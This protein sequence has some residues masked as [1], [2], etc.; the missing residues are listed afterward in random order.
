MQ[1]AIYKNN[2]ARYHDRLH[3]DINFHLFFVACKNL[4]AVR[5]W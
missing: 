3:G 5:L 2:F 1:V 4:I